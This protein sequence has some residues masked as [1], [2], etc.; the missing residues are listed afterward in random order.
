MA[1]QPGEML[2]YGMHGVCRVVAIEQRKVDRKTVEYYCICLVEQSGSN[3]YIPTGSPAAVS[4][5]HPLLTR[6][7][8]DVLLQSVKTEPDAWIS[9]ENRRKQHYRELVSGLDRKALLC[10]VSALVHHKNRQLACGKKLH[11]CDENFLRDAQKLISGEFSMVL[12]IPKGEVGQY[13]QR[14]LE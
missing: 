3:F 7:E 10:T 14:V 13:I 8:L 1:F 6:Q 9:D 12:G 11:L 2:L 5:L 4:K